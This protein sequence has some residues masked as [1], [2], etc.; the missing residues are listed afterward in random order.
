[1]KLIEPVIRWVRP[2][3]LKG[4]G[5]LFDRFTPWEGEREIGVSGN[6]RMSVNL[7]NGQQRQMF[8]GCF[9]REV[10][11]AVISLLRPGDTFLDVGANVG[12]LTLLGAG[13]V[14]SSG[15]VI[16]V[17]PYPPTFQLLQ[18]NVLS[19]KLGFVEIHQIALSSE[20]GTL[21]LWVPAQTEHR[22]FNISVVQGENTTP[23]DVPAGTLDERLADWK[24][25]PI[26]LMKI[27]VE[28]AEPRVFKGGAGALRAGVVRHLLCE[29]NGKYL[30]R[31]G[32]SPMGL[33]DQLQELG[34]R[35]GKLAQGR[36]VPTAAPKLE[37]S[38]EIDGLFIHQTALSPAG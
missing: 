28:G 16:G 18:K 11:A 36:V 8:M 21:R 30:V 24:A 27:D 14:G 35:F 4:A 23:V 38:D 7:A 17:E 37:A 2:L 3:N 15:R 9:A 6:I 20:A 13:R 25:G 34:F 10:Q 19:N 12:F 22:E 29:I 31:Q 5:T 32:T 1:M 26:Q 33:I